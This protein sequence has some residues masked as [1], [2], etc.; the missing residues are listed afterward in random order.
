MYRAPALDAAV[1]CTIHSLSAHTAR[2]A[3]R[4]AFLE[5]LKLNAGASAGT[6]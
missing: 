6:N 5:A 4:Y 2:E 3:A 1:D